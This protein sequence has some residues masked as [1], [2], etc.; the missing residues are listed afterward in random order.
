[1][2]TSQLPTTQARK[3]RLP[4]SL[5]WIAGAALCLLLLAFA[6][7][8]LLISQMRLPRLTITQ[9]GAVTSVAITPNGRTIFTGNY[10]T[11]DALRLHGNQPADVF[12]WDTATG[13]LIRRLPGFY[14]RSSGVAAS[15]DG[16]HV[17]AYG[18]A[19][20]D[21]ADHVPFRVMTWDWQNGQKQWDIEGDTPLSYSPDERLVGCANGIYNAANGKL[22]C[23]TS[24][25]IGEDGQSAFTPDDKLFGIIG[26]Y[27]VD[28]KTG[29]A[30]GY[31]IDPKTGIVVGSHYGKSIYSTTRLHFWHT[32]TG[33]EAEDFPF[34][35]VRAFDI[36][37]D[38]QW[39]VM[40]SDADDFPGGTD[41][42]VVRRVDIQTGKVLWTRKRNMNKPDSDPE[43]V[44]NSVAISPS[45]K[46]VVL[47]S[48]NNQL[49]VLDA[50]TGRELFRPFVFPTRGN[51]EWAIPGGL[52]F[53]ADGKTL[54]SRCGRKT[55]VWDST[56]LQ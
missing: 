56:A 13:R 30:W 20:R 8:S 10:P 33:K 34:T 50:Q 15:P 11:Y 46:Y 24:K 49:I 16:Q 19:R 12:V 26:G 47:A 17:I 25:N 4:R 54:V 3:R 5:R 1:M 40:T 41:G 7:R 23:W 52:A 51:P 36:A 43:A 29:L 42:S 38:G 45:G 6:A 37:R 53:S 28:L 32:D 21:V 35:R 31:H 18:V 39:L 9:D 14:W 27:N 2:A 44:L 55:L 48:N 22:I